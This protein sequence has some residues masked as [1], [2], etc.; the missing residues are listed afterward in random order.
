MVGKITRMLPETVFESLDMPPHALFQFT[1]MSLEDRHPTPD[2]LDALLSHLVECLSCQLALGTLITLELVSGLPNEDYKTLRKLLS[3]VT[4]I[5]H[6]TQT[7]EKLAAYIGVLEAQGAEEAQSTFPV[8]AE[9]LKHCKLCQDTI[10]GTR[11][12]LRRAEQPD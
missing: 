8:L 11:R 1:A 12:L 2:E 7:Q 4:G 6:K 5:I 9:H 3:R 10:E